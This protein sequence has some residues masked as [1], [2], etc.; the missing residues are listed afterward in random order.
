[1]ID[2]RNF[3]T[4][5]AGLSVA[6][7]TV[8]ASPALLAADEFPNRPVTIV[9]PATPGGPYDTF[10]RAL[11]NE[12][13][14]VWKQPVI[15]LN[16]PGAFE[17]IAAVSVIRSAPDGYTLLAASEL[18]MTIAPHFYKAPFDAQKDLA[19]ITRMVGYPLVLL[20]PKA[21]PAENMRD[22]IALAQKAEKTPLTF[23]SPGVGSQSHIPFVQFQADAKIRMTHVPYRG[24]AEMMLAL[25]S[26]EVDMA[27][28][29]FGFAQGFI[30]G[31]KVKPIATTA[32]ARNPL[33]PNL[34]T[35]AEAGFKD[36]TTVASLSLMAPKGTPPTLIN[37][38]A[39]AV[40]SVLQKPEFVSKSVTFFGGEV[41][42]SSPKELAD[43]IDRD[44]KFQG[45]LIKTYK[46][47]PE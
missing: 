32:A 21:S 36:M 4:L 41:V 22:L 25:T 30:A 20:V 45:N 13:K 2:I 16:K 29:T 34:P 1:M 37:A 3:R 11:S 5:I 40:K 28:T 10:I 19:P 9:V 27:L 14:D 33:Y 46:I 24:G 44:S 38:I 23:G 12:L 7:A 43:Y 42:G 18:G 15:V 39:G 8:C 26:G 47:A 17:S 35:V 31:G 6:L